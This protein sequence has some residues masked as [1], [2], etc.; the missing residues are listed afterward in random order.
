M[1]ENFVEEILKQYPAFVIPPGIIKGR[2][3]FPEPYIGGRAV[4]NREKQV[5]EERAH[6]EHLGE[7]MEVEEREFRKPKKESRSKDRHFVEKVER[8]EKA[9]ETEMFVEYEEEQEQQQEES[10]SMVVEEEEPVLIHF[11]ERPS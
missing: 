8:A 3:V 6:Q 5:A 11:P 1:E 9:P 7:N 4:N 10:Q 2:E